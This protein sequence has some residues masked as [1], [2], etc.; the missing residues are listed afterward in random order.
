M[1]CDK[2]RALRIHPNVVRLIGFCESPPFIV[3]PL[4]AG[5]LYNYLHGEGSF[6]SLPKNHLIAMDFKLKLVTELVEGMAG[7]LSC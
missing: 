4:Y 2:N 6:A 1:K 7:E 3:T 5:D